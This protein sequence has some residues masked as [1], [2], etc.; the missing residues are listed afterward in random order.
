SWN[1][2]NKLGLS[3]ERGNV[4]VNGNLRASGDKAELALNAR[5]QVRLNA[6][7]SLTGRNARLELNSGK[8]HKLADGVRVTLSGAG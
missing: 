5:D 2:G 7:L 4:E 3:A 6:D 8:G 1:S